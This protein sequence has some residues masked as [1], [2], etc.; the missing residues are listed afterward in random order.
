M[1]FKFFLTVSMLLVV[2]GHACYG[3][4][5]FV[6]S[7]RG[8][9]TGN[10]L[11][12]GLQAHWKFDETSGAPQD[13]SG[14]A[15]HLTHYGTLE[16]SDGRILTSRNH[17]S[18]E[19]DDYF[20][21]AS[22]AW[23]TFG[24]NNFTVAYWF[25]VNA[26]FVSGTPLDQFQV[27]KTD[28]ISGGV[29]WAIGVDRGAYPSDYALVFYYSPDG[30]FAAFQELLNVEFSQ[31]LVANDVWWF[32]ALTRSGS[33]FTLYLAK[34]TDGTVTLTDTATYSGTLYDNS[35]VQLTVGGYLAGGTP[36]TTQDAEGAIDELGI[37]NV[38]LSACQIVKLFNAGM[39]RAYST[40]DANPCL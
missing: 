18:A 22:A 4:G 39:G 40:F 32:V 1:R 2:I 14:N 20:G 19:N 16:T 24:T 9:T 15:R 17:D 6:N 12:T 34:E 21:R 23:N 25:N 29:S 13:S 33:T 27:A 30:T 35:T 37:W 26:S 5:V 36:D 31:T 28:I 38:A 7:H 8:G 11:L 10:N 3:Q